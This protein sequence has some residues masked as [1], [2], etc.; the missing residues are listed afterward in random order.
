MVSV[1]FWYNIEN[2]SSQ[3]KTEVFSEM[4]IS[5]K[6]LWIMLAE[7]EM[8]KHKLRKKLN[9]ATST[10]TKLCKGLIISLEM[11]LRIY[12]FFN[13]NIGD[14]SDTVPEYTR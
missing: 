7:K 13:C 2:K 8:T 10:M 3:H 5:Y 1:S 9:L 14:I 12:V 4:K 11:L 6:K